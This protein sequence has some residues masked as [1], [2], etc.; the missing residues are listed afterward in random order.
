MRGKGQ[1]E[2]PHEQLQ[3]SYLLRISRQRKEGA[4]S[5]GKPQSFT[6]NLLCYKSYSLNVELKV[7]FLKQNLAS[8]LPM[9]SSDTILYPGLAKPQVCVVVTGL[10]R[11][12]EKQ[13]YPLMFPQGEKFKIFL[14]KFPTFFAEVFN[15]LHLF[16]CWVIVQLF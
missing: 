10:G 6:S 12:R 1:R 8:V 13:R 4:T 9:S 16:I 15:I 7:F 11:W 2:G 5:E 14:E 3:L